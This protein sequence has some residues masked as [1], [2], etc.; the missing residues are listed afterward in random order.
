MSIGRISGAMLF[1]DLDRQG[2]DLQFTTNSETL[3]YLDF[4]DFR[5]GVNTDSPTHTLTVHG[6]VRIG[7]L[8]AY[9]E[10]ITTLSDNG[11][12]ELTGNGNGYVIVG[13]TIGKHAWFRGNVTAE[14][15]IGNIVGNIKA[16]G[17]FGNVLTSDGNG[18]SI[19]RSQYLAQS[20]PPKKKDR[21][22]GDI[23]IDTYD[24]ENITMY[25][26]VVEPDGN[27]YFYDFLPPKY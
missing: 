5:L 22:A 26:W 12:I 20:A 16:S 8:V 2:T 9:N 19:W 21:C 24:P 1:S 18:S 27:S 10:T 13:N 14:Y 23:W 25:M 6:N 3:V 4:T 15:F 11:N 7:N 17:K